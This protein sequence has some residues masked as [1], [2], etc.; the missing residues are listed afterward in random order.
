MEPTTETAL[1]AGLGLVQLAAAAA[2]A[3]FSSEA[4]IRA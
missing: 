4:W 3:A 1:V 2:A